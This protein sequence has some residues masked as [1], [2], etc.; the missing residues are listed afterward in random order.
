[1]VRKNIDGFQF[2]ERFSDLELIVEE[3]R[4]DEYADYINKK[5][6]KH[7][8][9]ALEEYRRKDIDFIRKCTGIEHLDLLSP[10][11]NDYS[12]VYDLEHLKV[13]RLDYPVVKIDLAQ[14]PTLEELY[15]NRHQN[16]LNLA[17]CKNLRKLSNAFYN[18]PNNNFEELASLSNLV[19]INVYRSNIR[20]FNGIG[21]LHQLAKMFIYNFPNLHC[22]DELEKIS[23]S[24]VVLDFEACKRIENYEYVTCLKKLK[25][26]KFDNCGN[27]PNIQFIKQMPNLKAFVFVDSNIVDGDL[28]PCV[29]LEYV[30]FIN[31]RHYSH[32]FED[33]PKDRLS[34]EIDALLKLH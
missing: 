34:T 18:P 16:I 11:I 9:I 19:E 33:F 22:L 21:N 30:G 14:I 20:S 29:G 23:D 27:I 24:L 31:K 26:L 12:P 28:S 2:F 15:V 25:V 1:M 32:K 8:S 6:I 10:L 17:S 3:N 7:V 13:L 5:N 4:I